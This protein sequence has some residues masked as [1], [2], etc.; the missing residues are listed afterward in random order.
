MTEWCHNELEVSVKVGENRDEYE[1]AVQQFEE[2]IAAFELAV[3]RDSSLLQV[4][5]PMPED[6]SGI[7]DVLAREVLP[8]QEKGH[9][10]T[11]IAEAR[12]NEE[13]WRLRFWG[14]QGDVDGLSFEIND[15]ETL[16][17]SFE[18]AWVPPDMWLRAMRKKYPL[19]EFHLFYHEVVRRLAGYVT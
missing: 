14:V 7:S 11:L 12:S 2:L 13:K 18:S 1:V 6:V 8:D 4:T 10:F 5:V 17:A 9:L 16:Y 19:L 3:A 15:D